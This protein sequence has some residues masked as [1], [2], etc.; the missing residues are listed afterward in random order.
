MHEKTNMATRRVDLQSNASM[1][2]EGCGSGQIHYRGVLKLAYG[3]W[4]TGENDRKWVCVSC[5]TLMIVVISKS[6]SFA[7]PAHQITFGCTDPAS[8]QQQPRSL[9]SPMSSSGIQRIPSGM[10]EF[11]GIPWNSD[12]IQMAEASA[13]LVS[14]SIE[15]PM[16]SDRIRWN[17]M[18]TTGIREPPGTVSIGIHWNSDQIPWNSNGKYI[19]AKFQ[20]NLTESIGIWIFQWNSDKFRQI[21]I[22]SD[23][24]CCYYNIKK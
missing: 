23:V 4:A 21:P 17:L 9:P 5:T 13:I 8:Q 6:I 18:E 11:H 20:W 15:I 10:S 7:L 14:N 24:C 12:G 3:S 1:P 16:E 22:D 19:P 2:L